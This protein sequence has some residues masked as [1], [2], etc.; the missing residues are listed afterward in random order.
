MEE[1][2]GEVIE[3]AADESMLMLKVKAPKS[4]EVRPVTTNQYR[5]PAVNVA[6]SIKLPVC[7]E[8]KSEVALPATHWTAE[9]LAPVARKTAG[10]KA[11]EQAPM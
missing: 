8:Q 4:E 1:A 11:E 5:T 9:Q 2:A 3:R 7:G 6:R 10:L